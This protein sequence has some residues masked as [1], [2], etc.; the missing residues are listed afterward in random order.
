[1]STCSL[2][3][4]AFELVK[5]DI[6]PNLVTAAAGSNVMQLVAQINQLYGMTM[7]D[8]YRTYDKEII[9]SVLSDLAAQEDL[10]PEVRN[11]IQTVLKQY[12]NLIQNQQELAVPTAKVNTS[13]QNKFIPIFSEQLNVKVFKSLTNR[14]ESLIRWNQMN[15]II[16]T[17]QGDLQ[18]ALYSYKNQLFEILQKYVKDTG[19]VL[20]NQLT[21]VTDVAKYQDVLSK[22]N[23]LLQINLN[24][25][26]IKTD[27]IEEYKVAEALYILNNFDTIINLLLGDTLEIKPGTIG[28]LVMI[29]G[30]YNF[31]T[32]LLP[33][34]KF[35]GGLQ[36]SDGRLHANKIFEKFVANIPADTDSYIDISDLKR[37]YQHI[38]IKASQSDAASMVDW[39]QIFVAE[40]DEERRAALIVKFLESD[41]MLQSAIGK[42]IVKNL[43]MYLKN[44]NKD[45]YRTLEES[46]GSD[47]AEYMNKYLN[48]SA[49]F[50]AELE[51]NYAVSAVLHSKKGMQFQQLDLMTKVKK[52]EFAKIQRTIIANVLNG[53]LHYYNP[54]FV[55]DDVNALGE[56][57]NIFS[58]GFLNYM[59]KAWG[60]QLTPSMVQ[61]LMEDPVKMQNLFN[62]ISTANHEI[63]KIKQIVTTGLYW[64][65]LV[66]HRVEQLIET[67]KYDTDT[68]GF[69]AVLVADDEN[70]TGKL[71][72][73][74]LDTLPATHLKSVSQAFN[75]NI[76]LFSENFPNTDNIFVKY[77]ELSRNQRRS[78]Q[79]YSDHISYRY[80]ISFTDSKQE[81]AIK[82][83]QASAE[84]TQHVA[85]NFE[86]LD[87]ILTKNLFSNQTA[88][89]SDKVTIPLVNINVAGRVNKQPLS[90]RSYKEVQDL[91]VAQYQSYFNTIEQR[92]LSTYKILFQQ[93]FD[94][95]EEAITFLQ[96]TTVNTLRQFIT[97]NGSGLDLIDNV[98]YAI[99]KDKE[100][101]FNSELYTMIQIAKNNS[102]MEIWLNTSK[103][104]WLKSMD[105]T[106][107]VAQIFKEDTYLETNKDAILNLMKTEG[108]TLAWETIKQD[109]KR[110]QYWYD[111]S[112]QNK[113]MEILSDK[114]FILQALT[115]EAEIQITGKY[116]FIHTNNQEKI[117]YTSV[118]V[119]APIF[120]ANFFEN[121]SL[122]F[123]RGS[124]RNN[125]YVASYVP[126]TQGLKFGVPGQ[127]RVA[128]MHGIE[129]TYQTYL[130]EKV[131]QAI[132]DGAGWTNGIY[133]KWED[134]SVL[135]KQVQGTKKEIGFTI[136]P[137]G[138]TQTKYADYALSNSLLRASKNAPVNLKKL[139]KRMNDVAFHENID[140]TS[141]VFDKEF[142]F[143]HNGET[144]KYVG[145]EEST[146]EGSY[147]LNMETADGQI[148]GDVV[149]FSTVYEL[150][151]LVGGEY[152]YE[153]DEHGYVPSESSMEFVA[154]TISMLDPRL[155]EQIVA[156]IVP[157]DSTKSAAINVNPN[158]LEDVDTPITTYKAKTSYW[159]IQNDSSKLVDD[160]EVAGPTQVLQGIAF[161]GKNI[162][163]ASETYAAMAA[164]TLNSLNK[165]NKEFSTTEAYEFHLGVAQELL[166]SLKRAKDVSSA[167]E[168]AAN[169]IKNLKLWK[170]ADPN[171]RGQMPTLPYDSPEIFPKVSVNLMSKLNKTSIKS[172]FHGVAIVLNPS[173]NIINVY[174]DI[175]GVIHINED[176]LRK[177]RQLAEKNKITNLQNADDFI[178]YYL[179][180]SGKFKK[181]YLVDGPIDVMDIQLGDHI[182]VD[183]V[184]QV[185][186]HPQDLRNLNLQ[187]NAGATINEIS[188]YKGRDLRPSLI[189]YN[190]IND[191]IGT[192]FN[193]W[194]HEAVRLL[195]ED[196]NNKVRNQEHIDYFR[197]VLVALNKNE[198][199]V[200]LKSWKAK[201]AIQ[202]NS[203]QYVPGEQILPK[204]NKTKH[205][206]GNK[207]LLEVEEAGSAQF[208]ADISIK[209]TPSNFISSRLNTGI[210]A[211][212]L[213]KNNSEIIITDS[214]ANIEGL[215][216]A[217]IVTHKG[218]NWI[219]DSK[220]DIICI[221][222]KGNIQYTEMLGDNGKQQY[223]VVT[224]NLSEDSIKRSVKSASDVNAYFYS[225]NDLSFT[226]DYNTILTQ[227]TEVV[228]DGLELSSL[229]EIA[230]K[231]YTSFQLSNL[232]TS[233]RIPSQSLQSFMAMKTVAFTDN[234]YNDGYVNI[235]EILFQGSDFD[236][237]KAY[238]IM[239]DVDN[240]GIVEQFSPLADFTSASS[241]Y[242]STLLALPN[243]NILINTT[244]TGLDFDKFI[245]N[246]GLELVK[247]NENE[248]PVIDVSIKELRLI[249]QKMNEVG[250]SFHINENSSLFSLAMALNKHNV[251]SSSVG[252]R[253]KIVSN[254]FTVAND[255]KNLEHSNQLMNSNEFRREIDRVSPEVNKGY[256]KT[257][258]VLKQLPR[259]THKSYNT[260][261]GNQIIHTVTK[262][263][264][265]VSKD[266]SGTVV[267][268]D[269]NGNFYTNQDIFRGPQLEGLDIKSFEDSEEYVQEYLN[270]ASKFQ[271]L[272]P[273]I[274][275]IHVGDTVILR[276]KGQINPVK[277]FISNLET[278]IPLVE[279]VKNKTISIISLDTASGR[280]LRDASITYS[281]KVNGK[282]VKF[283]IW[284][285]PAMI[286]VN[287]M[288]NEENVQY[289]QDVVKALIIGEDFATFDDWK[290]NVKTAVTNV[291]FTAEETKNVQSDQYS[292]LNPMS[293]FILQEKNAIGKVN[294]GIFANGVKV[295][296]TLQQY[297]N[298]QY[299]IADET[300]NDLLDRHKLDMELSF[301]LNIDGEQVDIEKHITRLANT[302]ISEDVL[303]KLDPGHSEPGYYSNKMQEINREPAVADKLSMLISLA[304][305]N[306]K[307]LLLDRINAV[308]ELSS[309][310]I[311]LFSLGFS[312]QEVVQI[313]ITLFEPLVQE[314][315]INRF[316]ASSS[317][318]DISNL[319]SKVF[320][321]DVNLDALLKVQAVAAE[322]TGLA[323]ILKINQ[324]V[325]VKYSEVTDFL[326]YFTDLK[327]NLEATK[328]PAQ[329]KDWDQL[330]QQTKHQ[331][332]FTF[333]DQPLDVNLFINSPEYRN[334]FILYMDQFVTAFNIFDVIAKSPH[335]FAMLKAVVRNMEIIESF[336]ATAS[337]YHYNNLSSA[338][339]TAKVTNNQFKVVSGNVL[340]QSKMDAEQQS[341]EFLASG[342]RRAQAATIQHYAI[343]EF[344]KNL[345]QY[346]FN[347]GSINKDLNTEINSNFSNSTV[348]DLSTETGINLFREIVESTIIPRLKE[349]SLSENAFFQHLVQKTH[350]D[351][352]VDFFGEQT[353]Q[354]MLT[355][356]DIEDS[357]RLIANK[358]SGIKTVKGKHVKLGELFYL[359]NIIVHKGKMGGLTR[360]L[361]TT[362]EILNTSLSE[363]LNR[364]Y[365]T[366][367][368]KNYQSHID[369]FRLSEIASAAASLD[370]EVILPNNKVLN[371]INKLNYSFSSPISN[372]VLLGNFVA[373]LE[374]SLQAADIQIKLI[375][376]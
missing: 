230:Q 159:G 94:T 312:V 7:R 305:D 348:F 58:E 26:V 152:T 222:P 255:I 224:D 212:Q 142:Y 2:N 347:I 337:F 372:D 245:Q 11:N 97:A 195:E 259:E 102:L 306:A 105:T 219:T 220:G 115:T 184:P 237:D 200:S 121:H 31:K 50:M 20:Y 197:A 365:R 279:S 311:A 22:A 49:A 221:A 93:N 43:A 300:G 331:E 59:Q 261:I 27:S 6:V 146:E 213:V 110:A 320:I 17:S 296:S 149:S 133:S 151:E 254:I 119:N 322:F 353:K 16:V 336:S 368:D 77:P 286:R 168:I 15:G 66:N 173:E 74:N 13:I 351:I 326:L 205:N 175:N 123:G 250:T 96:S 275:D 327:T 5:S 138:L 1:M 367:G 358:N 346:T 302:V 10:S 64:E 249:L 120:M 333:V 44:Y 185:I 162:A 85:I 363:D 318:V 48:M 103:E 190:R 30:K 266:Q 339:A 136:T 107:T 61:M 262:S 273:N 252:L 46:S 156:K 25:E 33:Q 114:Y 130:G 248:E 131:A 62:F 165:L 210:H 218:Q 309:M 112:N 301:K 244:S 100:V 375:C 189:K 350:Y 323:R 53:N 258:N 199:Y 78:T 274:A 371:L 95:L 163:L 215:K 242:E 304:T 269:N 76:A 211:V 299:K 187:V 359:Y 357:F 42:N 369:W 338:A 150:W 170:V 268:Q 47:V 240:I 72:S 113:T 246:L 83:S 174:E 104:S 186:K 297:F 98:H 232:T 207:T 196:N 310:H 272:N 293:K 8:S 321:D 251:N 90:E 313:S 57:N 24:Q 332:H 101:I 256:K 287:S 29:D 18:G 315:R 39:S 291:K 80:D 143:I 28:K 343:G 128:V 45:Y 164:I 208:L 37:I 202:I 60:L 84:E 352:D 134:N 182:I 154:Y 32:S 290:N 54:N 270:R 126:F 316:N 177:G 362:D 111:S 3:A 329:I 38:H 178:D 225:G 70:R 288:Y 118:D 334:A 234:D 298:E 265:K 4:E 223:I 277:V 132:H 65:K 9:T 161:F 233:L 12:N 198:D 257:V 157:T 176:L 330:V 340:N 88:C 172:R 361:R 263:S 55:Y 267:Y 125:L 253:N 356:L 166:D 355:Q 180:E 41:T 217:E 236:I 87:N 203:L 344:L 292:L 247:I 285:H 303:R 139:F 201:N 317:K 235:Y 14:I 241:L 282:D 283:N 124:K 171:T 374:K 289:L 179:M 281:K 181:H 19:G 122:S 67:L 71:L 145:F 137:E 23:N 147:T 109:I 169:T 89:N 135:A 188:L 271:I 155:K 376:N 325:P 314:L 21:G 227:S 307:E 140:M 260:K 92:L 280:P 91:Y 99:N 79:K 204:V 36:E 373:N 228:G 238:T 206:L 127:M 148:I 35:D 167:P 308:P 214:S 328:N 324:G 342:N 194:Q 63:Q 34:Q 40:M 364:V 191:G 295:N 56:S 239:Y 69:T 68:I 106:I 160:G 366:I 216:Q 82:A 141:I 226:Q 193:F 278:L 209:L 345:K 116:P 243:S 117:D 144:V 183:G 108:E 158:M 86:F 153:K 52:H 231:L 192:K 370:K 341:R 229:E 129:H 75:Q 276:R 284:Q 294:V 349:G 319:I 264:G 335:F 51:K 81:H 354:S 73:Q 360:I